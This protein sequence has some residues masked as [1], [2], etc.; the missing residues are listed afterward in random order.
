V[1]ENEGRIDEVE[2]QLFRFSRLLDAQ[3]RL[4][5]LLGDHTSPAE[6]R[7]GLLRN[8]LK[9]VGGR[10][11]R[12]TNALLS[13]TV[14]LLR[15]HQT[16]DEAVQSLAESAVARRGEVVAQ[17]SAAAELT[18]AQRTRLSEVLSRIYDHPVAVQLQLNDELL[19]GLLISV[20][21]E[22]IDGTLKSR[23]IAA[24]AQL[25]D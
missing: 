20:G 7:V 22:V 3:P 23:L 2:D 21:D 17:V 18:E 13:H 10:S 6:G 5:I 12:I 24:E 15:G 25:P 11:N 14:E 4:A 16:A 1:A 8:V 9:S 19:G